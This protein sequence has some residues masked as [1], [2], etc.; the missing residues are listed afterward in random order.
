MT[1]AGIE[2]AISGD[3]VSYN[4]LEGETRNLWLDL[5][6]EI[7]EEQEYC[8]RV[9]A[10]TLRRTE[11]MKMQELI[12]CG[13][14]EVFILDTSHRKNG[15]PQ[16]IWSW[17]AKDR[18]ELP[19]YMRSRF[20][21]TDECKPVNGGNNILITSSGGGVAL[22][23]RESGEV[24]F[25]AGTPNAHSADLLPGGR[26]V[27]AA[28]H[29]SGGD[30]L[31][32]YDLYKSDR[33]LHSDELPWGHGVVWDETRQILWA[34]SD[35]DI[36]S[37]RLENWDT[38]HPSLLKTF[39]IKLPDTSGHD[40]IPVGDSAFLAVS[41]WKHCWLFDRDRREFTA[42]LTACRRSRC[43]KHF[44]TSCHRSIGLRS[45]GFGRMVVRDDPNVESRFRS[46]FPGRTYLQSTLECCLTWAI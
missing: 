34:L 29:A 39:S 16:K 31:I 27:V 20:G 28:S 6:Y 3:D 30:R 24:V 2:P 33:E 38:P 25:Y 7:S 8:G 40:M 45:S 15:L 1:I 12:V 23:E 14:D 13:W 42:S 32:I 5:L 41:T 11:E 22:I 19:E 4:S 10:Y 18:I 37:Y 9:Q 21:T 26:V 44:G 36:R 17:K 35:E 43:K 46:S